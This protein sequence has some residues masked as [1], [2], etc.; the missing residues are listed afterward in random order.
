MSLA[1]PQPIQVAVQTATSDYALCVQ[2]D[3]TYLYND[4]EEKVIWHITAPK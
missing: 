2:M 4:A 1:K 3:G